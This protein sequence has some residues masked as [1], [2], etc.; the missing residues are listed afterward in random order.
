MQSPHKT[1]LKFSISN[2]SLY[3]GVWV[4]LFK[5]TCKRHPQYYFNT[6]QVRILCA[7]QGLSDLYKGVNSSLGYTCNQVHSMTSFPEVRIKWSLD[8]LTK[9]G[10]LTE[11]LEQGPKRTIRRYKLTKAGKAIVAEMSGDMDIV[12]ERIIDLLYGKKLLKH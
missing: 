8:K 2:Y 11:E 12:H 3:S 1:R 4:A 10:L 7:I 9:D 5:L 6:S